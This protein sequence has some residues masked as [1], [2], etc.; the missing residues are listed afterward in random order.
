VAVLALCWVLGMW[1]QQKRTDGNRPAAG[2]GDRGRA[3]IQAKPLPKPKATPAPGTAGPAKRAGLR[4]VLDP[5]AAAVRDSA[6]VAAARREL[7]RLGQA[8]LGRGGSEAEARTRRDLGRVGAALLDYE[9]QHGTLPPATLGAGLSWRVAILP[10]LGE[11]ELYRQF[12]QDEPWDGPNNKPLLERMPA[13]FRAPGAGAKDHPVTRYRAFAGPGAA[14]EGGRGL[15]ASSFAD[16][17]ASTLLVVE[18][19]EAVPWT[20][21]QELPFGLGVPL[22]ALGGAVEGTFLG[23]TADGSVRAYRSDLPEPALRALITRAG[24]EAARDRPTPGK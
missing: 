11:G 22:P 17:P 10:Q 2:R 15:A 14:F 5:A 4:E 21:P 8:L 3:P 13:V 9:R 7:G 19:A 12:R 16:G 23:L 24:G 18:A 20:A 1:A 6:F